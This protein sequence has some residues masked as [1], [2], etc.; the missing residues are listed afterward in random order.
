MLRS[1]YMS[2]NFNTFSQLIEQ[3]FENYGFDPLIAHA[4]KFTLKNRYEG[5]ILID[6]DGQI[7]FMDRAT[8][9]LFDLPPGGAKKK[10]LHKFFPNSGLVDVAETGIP[11]IGRVQEVKGQ[12]KIVSRYPIYYEGRLLGAIG[13][14]V[15]HELEEVKKLESKLEAYQNSF[16]NEKQAKYTFA[17]IICK[18]IS[19]KEQIRRAK[20]FSNTDATILITGESGTGKE[21]F[22]HSIHQYSYRAKGPFIK[23]NC[24]ALPFD[25]VESELFGYEGGAFT[26]A[27]RKGK[28]GKF[29]LASGGTIFLDE[30]G[31]MPLV[32]Q[33]K[34]LRV[35]EEKKV[36]KIGSSDAKVIDFRIVAATNSDLANCIQKGS[37]REDLYFRLSSLN[38][39]IEPLRNRPED[40]SCMIEVLL[41]EINKRLNSYYD[42]SI[43]PAVISVLKNYDWP[44]NGR[45]LINVLEQSIINC[46][47]EKIIRVNHLP[48]Y[49]SEQKKEA[50]SHKGNLND[51]L[52]E[53][54]KKAILEYLNFTGGNKRK[55]ARLLGISRQSLY[56]KI[57]QLNL[58]ITNSK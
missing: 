34:L 11:Q 12:R 55:A 54:E 42:I 20:L 38:I 33:A 5:L 51:I 46:Y 13:K 2:N 29:E 31:A 53:A 10:H 23:V 58:N 7:V 47:P 25:L 44:G 39:N 21:L 30:I 41:P 49:I 24:A 45:E 18:S 26:G 48:V 28:K 36:Q 16:I 40:I 56:F 57:S 8:E 14:V 15:F 9:K 37:F 1:L 17:N 3:G 50:L 22:A 52:K 32:S 6:T 27:N 4:I 19:L 43:D 35:I